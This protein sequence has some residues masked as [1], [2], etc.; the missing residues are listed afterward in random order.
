[1]PAP[2]IA[3]EYWRLADNAT[4]LDVIY[5]GTPPV[6]GL[7]ALIDSALVRSDE[8]THRFVNHSLANLKQSEDLN[9]FA[10]REPNMTVMGTKPG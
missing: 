10:V 8:S 1:M 7:G 4:L 2:S 5:A 9:P 3:K 6:S